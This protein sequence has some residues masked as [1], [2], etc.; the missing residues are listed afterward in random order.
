MFGLSEN[1][2]QEFHKCVISSLSIL[3]VEGGGP[4]KGTFRLYYKLRHKF[5][6]NR[7]KPFACFLTQKKLRRTLELDRALPCG[8]GRRFGCVRDT[9][10]RLKSNLELLNL[11][12]LF[13]NFSF[14]FPSLFLH[15]ESLCLSIASLRTAAYE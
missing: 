4:D 14:E 3:L 9:G 6:V 11:S 8:D 7:K 5:L 15:D 12:R 1:L 10:G 2:P 13:T